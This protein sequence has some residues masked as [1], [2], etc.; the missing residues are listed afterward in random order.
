MRPPFLFVLNAREKETRRARCKE[1]ENFWCRPMGPVLLLKN[2]C[3]EPLR[4]R[5]G[6]RRTHCLSLS[7]AAPSCKIEVQYNRRL[8]F[9]SAPG[10]ESKRGGRGPLLGRFKGIGFS[11][12]GENRNPPSPERVFRL[13]LHEQK[14]TAGSGRAGPKVIKFAK[15]PDRCRSIMQN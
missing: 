5:F 13:F 4:C 1:K 12:E 2:N 8:Q 6:T 14:E 7:A 3:T 9:C 10:G 15:N 11:G